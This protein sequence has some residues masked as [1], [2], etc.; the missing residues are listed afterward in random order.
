MGLPTAGPERAI[1]DERRRRA[2]LIRPYDLSA[3]SV[4]SVVS[5]EPMPCVDGAHGIEGNKTAG[6]DAGGLT[7][8]WAASD[9]KERQSVNF[10]SERK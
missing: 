6:K 7:A 8:I 5:G 10:S 9:R 4:A 3:K 2:R 1:F